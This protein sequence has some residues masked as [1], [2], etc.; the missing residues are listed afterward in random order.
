MTTSRFIPFSVSIAILGV[1]LLLT[2]L[3]ASTPTSV[4]ALQAAQMLQAERWA[5]PVRIEN[6]N[7]S[8]RYPETVYGT[9]F[10]FNDALWFY[11]ATGTQPLKASKNRTDDFKEDLLPL[12][13]TIERGFKSF[14]ALSTSSEAAPTDYPSLKNGCVIE[15]IFS[16]D[17]LK[18]NG[19]PILA[20]KLLLYTSKNQ[21]RSSQRRPT[22]HCV[23]IYQTPT[24]MFY[25]DP[26][27]IDATGTL[28]LSHWD[29]REIAAEIESRYGK[30]KIE[31]AFF[32]PFRLPT[33]Q[34]ARTS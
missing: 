30:I 33:P 31:D 17:E 25:I 4:L 19:E 14:V 3:S 22:G 1:S 8:S 10:E 9:V 7:Q 23:L 15:S 13:R 11:T 34:M 18:Q 20:A 12:L 5:Q 26:P 24:G 28:K 16:L 29:A 2:P 32:E 21:N 6:T 27:K